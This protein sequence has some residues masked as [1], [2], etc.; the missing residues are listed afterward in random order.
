MWPVPLR[1]SSPTCQ[2]APQQRCHG[3]R[4]IDAPGFGVLQSA[5]FSRVVLSRARVNRPE[6][7]F[8]GLE[9]CQGVEVSRQFLRCG[10]ER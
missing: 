8:S 7:R 10:E 1:P 6:D 9:L 3:S 5:T 4:P 2:Q